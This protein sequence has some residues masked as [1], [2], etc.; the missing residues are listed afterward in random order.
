LDEVHFTGRQLYKRTGIGP[1]GQRI[2]GYSNANL[3]ET[4]SM[5]LLTTPGNNIPFAAS[6]RKS[7]NDQYDFGFFIGKCIRDGF[8]RPHSLLIMDNASVH[9]GSDIFS[10][11]Y[12]ILK[13]YDVTLL[14]LPAYSPELNPC[15]YVFAYLKNSLRAQR[16][17]HDSLLVSIQKTLVG[18]TQDMVIRMYEKCIFNPNVG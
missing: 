12:N 9:V 4:Y 6:I 17:H 13:D 7:S 15:E 14:L 2:L 18:L 10:T 8:I 11:I 1:R 3:N 5:T 16:N